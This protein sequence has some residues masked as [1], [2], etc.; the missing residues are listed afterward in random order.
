MGVQRGVILN[1]LPATKNDSDYLTSKQI[2]KMINKQHKNLLR[3]IENYITDLTSS[4]MSPLKSTAKNGADTTKILDQ[5]QSSKLSPDTKVNIN[6]FFIKANYKDSKGEKR[7]CY[8]ITKKG[9]DFIAHKMKGAKGTL[10][11]ALYIN[12]FYSIE[13]VKREKPTIEWKIKRNVTKMCSDFLNKTIEDFTQY[14]I[15]Q[16]QNPRKA[17]FNYINFNRLINNYTD[18][19]DRDNADIKAQIKLVKIIYMLDT[20]INTNMSIQ[21]PYYMIYDGCKRLITTATN[22]GILKIE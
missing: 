16:G 5:Y 18:I 13:N 1:N 10:F 2:A 14:S 8:L 11:T 15:T 21:A 4:K 22:K 19:L 20:Y 7:P 12:K 17:R 9:C 3:D 6:D